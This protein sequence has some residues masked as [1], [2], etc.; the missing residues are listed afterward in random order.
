M[1]AISTEETL[2]LGTGLHLVEQGVLMAIIP[3]PW[4]VPAQSIVQVFW[5]ILSVT[6]WI[7]CPDAKS[8]IYVPCA[9]VAQHCIKDNVFQLN[10][11]TLHLQSMATV[12][13]YVAMA[14]NNSH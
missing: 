12:N 8:G 5:S 4:K 1:A 7:C 11:F 14:L 10:V 9:T 6:Y 3:M 13:D 2:M